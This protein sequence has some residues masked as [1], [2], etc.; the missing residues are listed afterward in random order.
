MFFFQVQDLYHFTV[1][2]DSLFLILVVKSFRFTETI[3]Q[4][5]ISIVKMSWG[6]FGM[7]LSTIKIYYVN[8]NCVKN[9]IFLDL[10][11]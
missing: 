9:Q 10:F 5:S 11:K 8:S 2:F 3:V 6:F 1:S 4:E 7:N